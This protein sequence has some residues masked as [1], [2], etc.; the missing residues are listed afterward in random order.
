MCG[1]AVLEDGD[2][3]DIVQ[4]LDVKTGEWSELSPMLISRS[5][6]AA[7]YLN[8]FIYVVGRESNTWAC[9]FHVV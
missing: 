7:A 8:G 1:G 9:P 3:S 2:G 5:G 6:S 4:R